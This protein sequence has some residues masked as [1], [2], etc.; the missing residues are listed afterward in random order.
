MSIRHKEMYV[1]VALFGR[2]FRTNTKNQD[3]YLFA[4]NDFQPWIKVF[5]FK[6]NLNTSK[7]NRL[8][9]SPFVIS[10][11]TMAYF[12]SIYFLFYVAFV[13]R[14]FWTVINRCFTY[15]RS[16]AIIG[17]EMYRLVPQSS[18]DDKCARIGDQSWPNHCTNYSTRIAWRLCASDDRLCGRKV[19]HSVLYRWRNRRNTLCGIKVTMVSR[20]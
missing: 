12:G 17:F 15:S 13:L 20:Q 7:H 8:Y 16:S 3:K 10:R 9:R 2:I 19:N 18:N 4:V 6:C 1:K 14:K 11:F 5:S